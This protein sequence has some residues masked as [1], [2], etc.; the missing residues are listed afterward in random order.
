METCLRIRQLR[1]RES[2]GFVAW[3]TR[4]AQNNLRDGIRELERAKRPSPRRRV[5]PRNRE[6]SRV[7]LLEAVGCT[8]AIASRHAAVRESLGLLDTAVDQLP[9]TY[10][11]VVRLYDLDGKSNS[12]W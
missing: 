2:N 3:M 11:T 8:T 5:V 6:E 7:M 4:M 10:Q 1:S 12:R 9:Q